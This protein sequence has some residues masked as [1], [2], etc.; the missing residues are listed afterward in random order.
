[1]AL[2]GSNVRIIG[3][4]SPF[5]RIGKLCEICPSESMTRKFFIAAISGM[6]NCR[7]VLISDGSGLFCGGTQRTAF[8]IRMLIRVNPS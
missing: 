3:L 8:V 5:T 7:Q 1:M 6:R 4:V 2:V